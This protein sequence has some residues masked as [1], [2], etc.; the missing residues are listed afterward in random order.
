MSEYPCSECKSDKHWD[1]G[2]DYIFAHDGYDYRREGM[3]I[4]KTRM[5]AV[6]GDEDTFARD[7][8]RIKNGESMSECETCQ[9]AGG[10]ALIPCP[11]DCDDGNVWSQP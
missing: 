2:E 6:Y 4:V 8:N 10:D 7:W 1:C 3:E 11:A 5:L 9:G